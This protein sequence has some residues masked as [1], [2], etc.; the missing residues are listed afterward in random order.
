METTYTWP[1]GRQEIS[2]TL[3][4]ERVKNCLTMAQMQPL[5]D[6]IRAIREAL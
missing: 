3:P 6:P 2:F 1:Y 5:A 4:A